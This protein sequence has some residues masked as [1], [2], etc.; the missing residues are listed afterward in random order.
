M[1]SSSPGLRALDYSSRHVI[2]ARRF[3][4]HCGVVSDWGRYALGVPGMTLAF[5][6]PQP[7]IQG[8]IKE[9]AAGQQVVIVCE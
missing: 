5:G 4:R 2:W 7:L 1:R 8:V 3:T 6:M 9:E